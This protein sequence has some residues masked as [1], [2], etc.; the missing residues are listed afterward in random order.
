[1]GFS[2]SIDAD[3]AGSFEADLRQIL[4]ELG[5]ADKIRMFKD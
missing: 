4:E 5:L 2:V 1:V 3:L